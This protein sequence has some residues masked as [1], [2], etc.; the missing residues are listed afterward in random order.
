MR[1][2]F[3]N[4]NYKF[5]GFMRGRYGR[6]KL[7]NIFSIAAVILIILS[8]IPP[9]RFLIYIALAVLIFSLYRTLS[10]NLSARQKELETYERIEHAVTGKFRLWKNMWKY[11][12]THKYVKCP[13]CKTY[14]R[15]RK[16]PKGKTIRIS[17]P[18]CGN[19]I[20]KRT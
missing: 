9:L 17:C 1:D 2:F 7:Y 12:G 16:P 18:K 14:I 8:F 5:S 3:Q 10:R 4:L 6:D 13:D 11:R 20:E 19:S 15:I